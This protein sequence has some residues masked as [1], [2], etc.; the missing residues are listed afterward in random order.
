MTNLFKSIFYEPILSV[1]VFIYNN[2]AFHDL[3]LAI[4]F[5]T[6]LV[7]IV[8]FPLFYKSAKDQALLSRLQPKVKKIQTDLKHKK[9]EQAKALLALYR[10]HRFNPFL[11]VFLLIVQLPI[12]I[13][14][15]QIFTK[16]LE[17]ATFG[18]HSLLGFINLE[19]RS[20][21]IAFVAALLQYWQAKLALSG[22]SPV[23]FGGGAG[24]SGQP[25][26]FM[27]YLG[28]IFTL[29]VLGGLPAAL[30]VYWVVSGLFSLAQQVYI[31]KKIKVGV[32][33][34]T[35]ESH[36]QNLSKNQ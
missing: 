16:E 29:F 31:N 13:V 36:G 34:E 17:T 7:R 2:L 21:V 1:L 19:N 22:G 30:G 9:E 27:T 26:K 33:T 6:I 5:L 8:L 10:D 4:I 28:P 35:Q 32:A 11:S 24:K 3:G 18:N 12:F 15:F 25:L 14:L 23:G 20:L